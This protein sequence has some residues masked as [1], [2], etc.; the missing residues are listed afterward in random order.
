LDEQEYNRKNPPES[1]ISFR[2]ALDE[3]HEKMDAKLDA[4]LA[5]VHIKR[6]K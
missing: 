4:D 5:A 1:R 6:I 3:L 2:K